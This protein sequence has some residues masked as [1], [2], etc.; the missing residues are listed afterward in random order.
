[1]ELDINES[2][3][4]SGV[5]AKKVLAHNMKNLAILRDRVLLKSCY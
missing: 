2:L 1:M 3:G 5:E 4:M